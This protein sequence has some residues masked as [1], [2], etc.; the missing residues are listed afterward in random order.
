MRAVHVRALLLVAMVGTVGCDRITKRM[1]VE[2]LMGAP[3]VSLLG[4]TIRLDYTENTGG[5]LSA[6][7]GLP[8]RVRT[9]VFTVGTAAMLAGIVGLA[10]WMRWRG[11]AALGLALIVAG[12]ASNLADRILHGRV[13]DFLNVGLGPIRTGI[14]NVADVA[15]T[16]GAVLLLFAE[17]RRGRVSAS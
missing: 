2:S 11:M 9:A 13:V 8:P 15:I 1:A 17:I 12:G 6:G 5:F 16:A 10:L 3:A 14:F 7:A 4:D